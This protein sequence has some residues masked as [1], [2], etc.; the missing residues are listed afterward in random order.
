MVRW[1]PLDQM[2]CF[3][4]HSYE[5]YVFPNKNMSTQ[6]CFV[7]EWQLCFR[8]M[9]GETVLDLSITLTPFYCQQVRISHLT[10][11]DQECGYFPLI[12]LKVPKTFSSKEPGCHSGKSQHWLAELCFR[13]LDILSLFIIAQSPQRFF[14]SFNICK[15]YLWPHFHGQLNSG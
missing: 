4:M 15:L 7:Y 10:L 3:S 13:K 2:L 14:S 9:V 1:L 12:Q 8:Q 6:I 11:K 5:K